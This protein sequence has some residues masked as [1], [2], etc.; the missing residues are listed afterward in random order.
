MFFFHL[1]DH[2]PKHVNFKTIDTGFTGGF[3]DRVKHKDGYYRD[4][5]TVTTYNS[6]QIIKNG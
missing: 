3:F 4:T 6:Q 5:E 1:K 2:L